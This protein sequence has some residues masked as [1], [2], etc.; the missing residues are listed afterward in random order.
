MTPDTASE[1]AG[2]TAPDAGSPAAGHG[3]PSRAGGVL[4]RPEIREAGW[5]WGDPGARAPLDAPLPALVSVAMR[6]FGAFI[7]GT[8]QGTG[9]S[10]AG[11][12]VMR[13]LAARDGL[14]SSEVEERGWRTPGQ[15]TSVVGSQVRDGIVDHSR[16]RQ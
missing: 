2:H 13:L 9:V 6:L 1:T 15:V 5:A 3:G 12:G 7:A 4:D 14:K 11:V 8:M 16:L 10:T